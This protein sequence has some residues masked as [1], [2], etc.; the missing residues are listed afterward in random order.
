M[1]MGEKQMET[2]LLSYRYCGP[3]LYSMLSYVTIVYSYYVLSVQ[4]SLKIISQFY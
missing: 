1:S 4:N 2:G 3:P